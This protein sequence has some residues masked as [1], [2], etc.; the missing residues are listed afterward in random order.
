MLGYLGGTPLQI[1]SNGWA[2]Y[3]TGRQVG[4]RCGGCRL[5]ALLNMCVP[6]QPISRYTYEFYDPFTRVEIVKVATVM[7]N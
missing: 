7:P 1:V 4:G 2:V 3:N 6:S 5:T